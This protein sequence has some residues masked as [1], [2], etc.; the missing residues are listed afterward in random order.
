[1]FHDGFMG[2]GMWFGWIF[3]IAVIGV[4]I[5]AILRFTQKQ[6]YLNSQKQ[7][8]KSPLDIVKERYAKGEITKSEFDSMKKDLE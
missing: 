5:W 4:I 2:G 7:V 1:M 3:W 6:T 8:D